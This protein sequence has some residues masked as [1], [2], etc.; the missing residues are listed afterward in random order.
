MVFPDQQAKNKMLNFIKRKL[1]NYF[2]DNGSIPNF[3]RSL[4]RLKQLGYTPTVVYD[5]GAYKGDFATQCLEVWPGAAVCCFEPLTAQYDKLKAW[6]EKDKRITVLQGLIGSENK[7]NVVF[8]ESE[9]ASSVLTE[10]LSK[11][12]VTSHKMMRTLDFCIT[13]MNFPVPGLLKIDTQGYEYQVILGL[14]EH[15]DKVEVIIAELNHIDLH[16]DVKL[17]E[18]VIEILYKNNFI[19]YDIAEIHRRPYDSALWQTDFIFVKKDSPLR[20]NKR[21]K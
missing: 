16:K 1:K 13:G 11:D 14:L 8:N 15:I 9:T 7:S 12:F 19:M 4:Q 6:S 21:W 2:I 10:H 3:E 17:A 20:S 5:V 18:D